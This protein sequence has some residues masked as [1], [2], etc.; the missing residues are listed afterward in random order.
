[1]LEE[2]GAKIYRSERGEV[3]NTV[4]NAKQAMASN[5]KESMDKAGERL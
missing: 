4:A 3:E 2:Q 5:S 1:M